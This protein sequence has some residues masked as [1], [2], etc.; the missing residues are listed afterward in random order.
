MYMKLFLS[1]P[2][3]EFSLLSPHY[4]EEN[5][6]FF[7]TFKTT[8]IRICVFWVFLVFLDGYLYKATSQQSQNEVHIKRS[9]ATLSNG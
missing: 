2:H 7:L 3:G 9:E 6:P 5:V 1:A 8:K 4:G